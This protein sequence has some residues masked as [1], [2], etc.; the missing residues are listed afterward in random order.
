MYLQRLRDLREDAEL[1]QQDVAKILGISKQQYQLYESGKRSIPLRL[2]IT[3]AQHYDVSIDYIAG[4][5]VVPKKLN[6][7]E[8]HDETKN[9]SK[10][11]ELVASYNAAT[12][13]VK[14][15]INVLLNIKGDSKPC[16]D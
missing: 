13:Q 9:G 15:A 11:K 14:T 6:R 2:C 16:R 5:I 1:T 12:P 4:L 8:K 7:S 10:E 3:L